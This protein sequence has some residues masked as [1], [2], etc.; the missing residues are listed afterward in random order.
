MKRLHTTILTLILAL[1]LVFS[2]GCGTASPPETDEGETRVEVFTGSSTVLITPQEGV[3]VSKFKSSDFYLNDDGCPV[4]EGDEYKT[5]YGVDISSWQ[6]EI[7]WQQVKDD[8]I[9]F[10]IIRIGMRG[11]GVE[12]GNVV[13]DSLFEANYAGAKAAGL[14]VGVYFF[15]QAIDTSEA[16]EEANFVKDMLK[17]KSLDLPVYFDWEHIDYDTARTE[18]IS[19]STITDCAVAFC[20]EIELSGYDAGVYMYSGIAY[21]DYELSR[22][23][24]FDFWCAA[25]GDYPFFYY[26][27]NMWQYSFTGSVAGISTDCDMNMMFV[28]K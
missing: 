15:S 21:Y 24:D 11:Y 20:N 14:K 7:D 12:T 13:D 6:G 22:L 28:E 27:H 3:A 23:T 4:Y 10:A 8:G 16:I 26:A 25:I 2:V 9:D 1:T 17:G 5:L 19:G 18:G